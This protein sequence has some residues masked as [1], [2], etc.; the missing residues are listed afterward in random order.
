MS[1]IIRKGILQAQ[2]KPRIRSIVLVLETRECLTITQM[3]VRGKN[4]FNTG[5]QVT[6]KYLK[7]LAL[8]IRFNSIQFFSSADIATS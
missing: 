8:I 1:R 5:L 2:E 6:L 7:I 3:T 4:G